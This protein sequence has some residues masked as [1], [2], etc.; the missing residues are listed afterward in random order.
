[1]NNEK[2]MDERELLL[3]EYSFA[4]SDGNIYL[5][6]PA[7]L[8]DVLSK[9]GFLKK[10][11]TIGMPDL[12]EKGNARLFIFSALSEKNR[13][14]ALSEIVEKYVS[15]NNQPV[16]LDEI[17]GKFNVDDMILMYKRLIGISG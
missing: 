7:T 12:S 10:I 8:G 4:A 14:L 1:M 16:K 5:V 6:K 2:D 15:W 13:K 17:T 9:D 11:E 3:E